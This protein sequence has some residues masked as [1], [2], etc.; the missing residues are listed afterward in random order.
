MSTRP[1]RARGRP[2][3]TPVS[4]NRTNFLRKPKAY[5]NQDLSVGNSGSASPVSH[6]HLSGRSERTRGR[7]AAHKGRHFV[8]QLI[9]D[10]DEVSSLPELEDRSSDITD[11]DNTD[12]L[13][14]DDASDEDASFVGEDSE[15]ESSDG[16]SLSTVSSSVSRRKL[17]LKRP[18]TPDIPEDKDIPILQLPQSATDL[19]LPSEHVLEAVGVY[20]VLRH[21][22]TILRL[23]P[24]TFEDF[25]ACLLSEDQSNLLAEIHLTL[26][27]AIFREEESSNTAFGPQDLKDS[28]NV[29]LFFLDPMTWPEI[30]RSYLDS[31]K[32]PEFR[33]HLSILASPNYPFMPYVEKIKVLQTLTD[34]FLGTTKR[35]HTSTREP[36]V[37]QYMFENILFLWC[38]RTSSWLLVEV[39]EQYF[40]FYRLVLGQRLRWKACNEPFVVPILAKSQQEASLSFIAA[41]LPVIFSLGLG[42]ASKLLSLNTF[43]KISVIDCND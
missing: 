10:D 29:S 34:L 36:A 35:A 11:L 1:R 40:V 31:E 21:F 4:T 43:K 9:A 18:K 17:L 32:H 14:P 8:S 6:L 19:L 28:I 20:E 15:A 26:L 42:M 22:W 39:S 12:S 38:K 33:A 41:V 16:E 23:S 24:F 30:L 7:A 3:K 2:P 13:F 25:C 5:Q 37:Q 27:K